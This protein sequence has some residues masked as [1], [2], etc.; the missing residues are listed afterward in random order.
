MV[1]TVYILVPPVFSGSNRWLHVAADVV[2]PSGDVLGL[3]EVVRAP[4][5]G[6]RWRAV[7]RGAREISSVACAPRRA[8]IG[9]DLDGRT[10]R[11]PGRT[12]DEFDNDRGDVARGLAP[13]PIRSDVTCGRPDAGTQ[14]R[15]AA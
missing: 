7:A 13:P 5:R 3:D 2:S 10:R 11:V 15:R 8:R 1:Y 14:I 12:L 4:A 9:R 6:R